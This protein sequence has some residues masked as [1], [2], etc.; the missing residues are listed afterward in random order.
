M[1]Y[2]QNIKIAQVAEKTLVMG[3][4]I[5]SET[6]Y[7][8]AFNWRGQELPKKIYH[9]LFNLLCFQFKVISVEY[10][11]D[12]CTEWEIEDILDYLPY[13]D[14]AIREGARLSAF[15]TAKANFKNIKKLT[16]IQEFIWEKSEE[17]QEEEE[18]IIEISNE[19][20]KRLKE[21]AKQWEK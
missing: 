17:E 14:R 12:V 2:T 3:V 10:F 18:K 11:M 9:F 21:K 13:T 4:D 16:D 6:N 20:I 5:G 7:A 8:R 15:I 19:D 1:N